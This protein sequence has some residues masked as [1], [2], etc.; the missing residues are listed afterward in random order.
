MAPSITKG[1]AP[2]DDSD[3][4]DLIAKSPRSK[5]TSVEF[6]HPP[7]ASGPLGCIGGAISLCC[8]SCPRLS[9]CALIL[10]V[11]GLVGYL[12]NSLLN[13]TRTLGIMGGDYSAVKNA[14]ELSLSKVDHWCISGDN[15]SCKCEDPLEATPRAEFKAW[16]AAHKANVAEVNMYRAPYGSGP[17][18]IDVATG[19]PRPPIDVAFLGESVVEAM[20]GRW[21]GKKIVRATGDKEGQEGKKPDIGK[22]FER[23]FRKEKGGPLEGTAL[24]I[25]GDYTANV[26]W[27]LQHDEM[28]YDF[29]PKVWWLVLGMNDLTRMQ[30]SEEIVVLGILRVVEE[31]M[32]R[33]PDALI[34]INSLLPMIDY[35]SEEVKMA[36]LVDFKTDSDNSMKK[37]MEI[38]K[39]VKG[40][41]G[42]KGAQTN[43]P[44]STGG[45]W[46]FV[47]GE[48]RQE[49]KGGRNLRSNKRKQKL[50]KEDEAME[51]P[52]LKM[53][54][55]RRKKALDRRDKKMRNKKFSDKER[56][57]PKK[58]LSPF[59]PFLKKKALPPVWPAVHLINEKLKEFCD[60]HDSVTFFDATS[61]FAQDV[62]GGRHHLETDLISPRGHPS[63]LGFAVWEA[64]IMGQLDKMFKEM[65]PPPSP[66]AVPGE[67][68]ADEDGELG[69]V[70]EI[71]IGSDVKV[72]EGT[73]H[74]SEGKIAVEPDEPVKLPPRDSASADDSKEVKDD[75]TEENE[76]DTKIN[77]ATDEDADDEEEENE[78]NAA[79]EDKTA[80][81][82][83]SSK[84]DAD[85]EEDDEE[86]TVT[87]AVEEE[88]KKEDADNDD[89]K[90][91]AS[92]AAKEDK[93][94]I[95]ESSSKRDAD[96]EG[97]EEEKTVTKAVEEELKKEDA[98]NDDENNI[99]SK[100]DNKEINKEKTSEGRSKTVAII[101]D[102]EEDKE[103]EE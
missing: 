63:E 23:F 80:V 1:T 54:M 36:D 79:K 91:I 29:N 39:A 98:D 41:V 17:T 58:P 68:D 64:R 93:K 74:V 57:H 71:S 59:L 21:L 13:P 92:K 55:E 10:A 72:A 4:E 11:I 3:L 26:L 8:Y 65:A 61:I 78:N 42:Q 6:D 31:I 67:E 30:C 83:A 32:L 15:D 90:N 20:D 25:A 87:K 69:D 101:N 96:E 45:T 86:K 52:N 66:A 49:N 89:E 12:S 18:K 56:F 51:G 102:E 53:A 81:K 50:A 99:A 85:E 48:K 60:K 19:K 46:K 73:E 82:E 2:G 43:S 38:E 33:K 84:R 40:F 76:E 9:K 100:E 22:V 16:T 97:G 7:L 94:A 24:G 37:N 28:P 88:L 62:G 47:K 70:N 27:R 77:S 75:D 35:R 95:K 103:E 44:G 34:V 14:Y 5:K